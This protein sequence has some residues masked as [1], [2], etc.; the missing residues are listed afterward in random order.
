MH[1]KFRRLMDVLDLGDGDKMSR[2]DYIARCEM[3][4]HEMESK[5]LNSNFNLDHEIKRS[6]DTDLTYQKFIRS[7]REDLRWGPDIDTAIKV[8]AEI[9]STETTRVARRMMNR[10]IVNMI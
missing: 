8:D 5:F 4:Q 3:F 10:L 7:A 6:K 1:I 2:S 9:Y